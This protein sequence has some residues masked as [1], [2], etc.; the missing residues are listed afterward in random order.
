[1]TTN[2][3]GVVDMNKP[4]TALKGAVGYAA[5]EF[6]AAESRPAEI[7]LG[8]INGWKVWFNGKFLFGRDEYHRNVEID[9]YRMPVTLQKGRNVIVVKIC[10]NEQTEDWAAAWEFQLRITDALGTPIVP[11]R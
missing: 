1:M 10:Q 7:R 8:C 3:Y 9:Q 2:D 4:F 5:A 6:V 11:V